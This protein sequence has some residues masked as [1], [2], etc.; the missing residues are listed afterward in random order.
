MKHQDLFDK[1]TPRQR[2]QTERDKRRLN[3][4]ND[5][6]NDRK[7]RAS[8]KNYLRQLTEEEEEALLAAEA[9]SELPMFPHDNEDEDTSAAS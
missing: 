8:F 4:T 5:R 1:H 7:R 9:D 3:E 2:G 6:I